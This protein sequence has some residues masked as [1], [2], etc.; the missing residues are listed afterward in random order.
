MEKI[1]QMIDNLIDAGTKSLPWGDQNEKALMITELK[2]M[3]KN[4][5]AC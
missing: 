5:L 2:D 4:Q 3:A 1:N